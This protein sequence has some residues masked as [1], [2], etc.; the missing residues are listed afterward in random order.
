MGNRYDNF[1]G[2]TGLFPIRKSTGDGSSPLRDLR[3]ELEALPFGRDSLLS[4]T[5]LVHGA[6]MFVIDDVVFN[7]YPAKEEHLNHAYLVVSVTFDGELEQLVK[8]IAETGG[9]DWT[10]V[11]KNTVAFP[12]QVDYESI[13]RHV[14]A[15][16]LTTS[17]LYV[18]A[19]ADLVRTL[20]ALQAQKIIFDMVKTNQSLTT[21][22]R[23]EQIRQTL[24]R[25]N[26]S[27]PTVPGDYTDKL[28]Q[29]ES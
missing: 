3:R 13:L 19:E 6:R 24:E 17:F 28:Y 4:R 20:K 16:Q 21:G 9:D 23:R 8:R 7:G 27:E 22:Q 14:K 5:G 12:E 10:K 25:I 11:F 26:N 2:Y 29:H 18:D 1:Y 15:C